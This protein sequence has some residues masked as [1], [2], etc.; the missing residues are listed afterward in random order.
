MYPHVVQFETRDLLVRQQLELLDARR[1]AAQATRAKRRWWRRALTPAVT[2]DVMSVQE[3]EI[4]VRYVPGGG[5]GLAAPPRPTAS[6]T[7]IRRDM[8]LLPR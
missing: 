2:P 5:P 1:R 6:N 7:A 4:F 8:G 3:A